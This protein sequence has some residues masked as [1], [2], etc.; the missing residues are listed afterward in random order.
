MH[1]MGLTPGLL[2]PQPDAAFSPFGAAVRRHP[3]S[4]RVSRLV[5]ERCDAATRPE[6]GI[7]G[8]ARLALETTL[9]TQSALWPPLNALF[10]NHSPSLA[11]F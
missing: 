6:P 2:P 9:M 1:P 7:S 10:L 4:S 3:S 8:S 5:A 11:L